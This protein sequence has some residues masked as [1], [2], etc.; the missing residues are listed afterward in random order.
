MATPTLLQ[1]QNAERDLQTLEDVANDLGT[2]TTRQ[3]ATVKTVRQVILDAQTAVDGS[4]F[5]AEAWASR[6]ATEGPV[7]YQFYSALAYAQGDLTTAGANGGG[8]AK[9]WAQADEYT[10][11][12]GNG[13]RSAYAWALEAKA[14]Y[15]LFGSQYLGALASDPAVDQNGNAV[16]VGDWYFN[17]VSN[18]ARI[19]DGASWTDVVSGLT[20]G[21]NSDITGLWSFLDNN[22]AIKDSAD[23][24]KELQF[25]VSGVTTETTRTLTV[26][27]YD[28]TIAT[29]AGT[30]TLTNKTLSGQAWQDK[31]EIVESAGTGNDSRAAIHAARDRVGVGGVI[32]LAPGQ[33]YE[34]ASDDI[35]LL[36]GQTL[37]IPEGATLKGV[38]GGTAIRVVG[39]EDCV[40]MGAGTIDANNGVGIAVTP[41]FGAGT[42]KPYGFQTYGGLKIINTGRVGVEVHNAFSASKL[43]KVND[44][45]VSWSAASVAYVLTN[46]ILP[47]GINLYTTSGDS[48]V[49]F[50]NNNCRV[51]WSAWTPEDISNVR[52]PADSTGN[53]P[54]GIRINSPRT[55]QQ[56]ES[57]NTTTNVF[58]ITGHGW[59]TEQEVRVAAYGAVDLG[60]GQRY[61]VRAID[62][63]TFTL[64][65]T[66]ADATANQ[67][68]FDATVSI[69]GSSPVVYLVSAGGY[70]DWEQKGNRVIF[71]VATDGDGDSWNPTYY[72]EDSDT[73]GQRRPTCFETR[74]GWGGLC[75]GNWGYGGDL[76]YSGGSNSFVFRNN[77]MEL[78]T[79]YCLETGGDISGEGN[80]FDGRYANKPVAL[81]LS[82]HIAHLPNSYI[83]GPKPQTFGSGQ[84][85]SVEVVAVRSLDLSGSILEATAASQTMLRLTPQ[86]APTINLTGARFRGNG[87]AS[88]KAIEAASGTT[89]ALILN[90]V[91]FEDITG[92][93]ID[94]GASA[95]ITSL[96]TLGCHGRSAGAYSK[97]G[98]VTNH[99][100]GFNSGVS[101]LDG[102]VGL[103]G[104]TPTD[105]NFLVGNGS[106]FVTESG[107]TART[108]LGLGTGNSP[109][110][111]G[112]TVAGS[113]NTSQTISSTFS[114]AAMNYI[115]NSP[116]DSSQNTVRY[117][118]SGTLQG[119]T[120]YYHAAAAND[121]RYVI[122]PAGELMHF[123]G[124]GRVGVLKDNPAYTFDCDGDINVDTGHVYRVA[125]T[126]VV[127]AQVVD[128]NLADTAALTAQ[129]LTDN[130]G[131]SASDTIAAIGATYSQ[132]E[133]ANA[134]ASLA[135]E[136]NKLRADNATQKTAL[137]AALTLIRTHGLGAT[138]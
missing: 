22:F 19:Y 81:S 138:S 34:I 70:D 26:P 110:F 77:R 4:S 103:G 20:A 94:V 35:R 39:V 82:A 55:S 108:S 92:N 83:R 131:G 40:V 11:I 101:G 57:V 59:S 7:D 17:T 16:T 56:I 85:T 51:D 37:H 102:D 44:V 52:Y 113:G 24:T 122:A 136:I 106:A 29:L 64:H 53:N 116:G 33:P 3:G 23:T 45:T 41:D 15:E 49:N 99:Y 13:G 66:A 137:D 43:V 30:E 114:N 129:T 123:L 121:R 96:Y 105:G 90:G 38:E 124:I 18:K 104:F 32:M 115:F 58:T 93:S 2:T 95:T 100:D 25:Q 21:G 91:T 132:T 74:D 42:D 48:A 65:P 84:T 125:G 10:D 63:D 130:S 31:F 72:G 134:I 73:Q 126:P 119:Y 67:N 79:T 75:E 111:A 89:N 69:S 14:W 50:E 60:Q 135:D 36:E 86:N 109:Q 128:A 9:D 80:Y 1:L 88:V 112:L 47:M 78:Q 127:G 117:N 76:G 5:V 6:D 71:P 28:G 107:N 46:D 118:K 8:S 68:A 54:I 133:V 62:A 97:S 61:Y 87:L 12:D 120:R 98:T 27:D